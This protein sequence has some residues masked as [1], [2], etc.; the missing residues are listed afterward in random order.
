ML[1]T[2]R[3]MNHPVGETASKNTYVNTNDNNNS[4][5]I[6]KSNNTVCETKIINK[7]NNRLSR[8]I[9]HRTI[10]KEIFMENVTLFSAKITE[11][12]RNPIQAEL[13]RNK[14]KDKEGK[15]IELTMI[16]D[17]RK[18]YLQSNKQAFSQIYFLFVFHFRDHQTNIVG[19]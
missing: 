6:L 12:I 18:V 3:L 2:L 8:E 5:Y 1:T 15:P 4:I 14:N 13:M 11:Y 7:K 16:E 17:I 10:F 19:K 9:I